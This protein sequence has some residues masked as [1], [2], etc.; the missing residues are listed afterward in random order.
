MTIECD[1][2]LRL[3]FKK[4]SLKKIIGKILRDEKF[5]EETS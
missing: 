5:F 2:E 1:F 4:I 3:Y